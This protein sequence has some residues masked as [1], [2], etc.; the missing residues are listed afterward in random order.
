M[1]IL[2]DMM[3][4]DNAPLAPLQG[5]AEAV[6]EYG[7]EVLALG[8]EALLRKVA[9]EN[10]IPTSG[11]TFVHCTEVIEMCDEPAMAIR[12]KK[13]STIVRGLEMLKAGEAD[14]IVSAG[15]TGA[16]HVGASLIVRT[17]KGVKRPALA[18]PVPSK[19]KPYLL[20]DCGA[21]GAVMSG[22]GSALFG[23]FADRAAAEQA[24]AA[25]KTQCRNVYLAQPV[26]K[27]I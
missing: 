8:D 4:G 6:A 14:A 25:L 26:G 27:L 15:S 23:I 24:Y 22:T 13:D 19:D 11:L 1:K 3:G 5:A 10:N 9:A 18:A 21:L 12:R 2:V 16:L 17:L 7:V 20:L